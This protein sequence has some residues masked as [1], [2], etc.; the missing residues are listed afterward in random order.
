MEGR[1][2]APSSIKSRP[3]YLFLQVDSQ[4]PKLLM[5]TFKDEA[6]TSES[7]AEEASSERDAEALRWASITLRV[8]GCVPQRDIVILKGDVN[9]CLF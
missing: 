1:S 4:L 9:M 8:E 5:V 2:T 7:F 6:K 3:T